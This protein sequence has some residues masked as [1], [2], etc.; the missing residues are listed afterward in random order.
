MITEPGTAGSQRWLVRDNRTVTVDRLVEALDHP[1]NR[2]M[3]V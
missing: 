1:L 3:A 2:W